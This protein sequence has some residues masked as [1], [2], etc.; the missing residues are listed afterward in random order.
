MKELDKTGFWN[1][2]NSRGVVV[3]DFWAPW[4]GPCRALAPIME[5]VSQEIG[6][7]AI[8]AKM[9][10]DECP[11]IAEEFGILSIPTLIYFKNGKEIKRTTGMVT[12]ADILSNA[13]SL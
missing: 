7:F 13:T 5:Q 9:S 12:K 2:V 1:A 10:V 6:N 8:V 4:C 11:E 3:V